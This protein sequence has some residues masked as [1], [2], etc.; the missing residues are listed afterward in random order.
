MCI[1]IDFRVI[2]G[3]S[4]DPLSIPFC[5][6]SVI[7]G[8]RMGDWFQ[9]HVFSDPGV[10]MLLESSGCMCYRHNENNGFRDISRFPLIHEFS[11]SREGFRCHF[12][13]FW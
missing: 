1:F 11:V 9:V 4:W 2:L 13:V 8:A 5:E 7:L 10:E 12:G 3:G 6:F